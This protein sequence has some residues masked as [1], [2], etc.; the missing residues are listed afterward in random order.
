[1]AMVALPDIAP[2]NDIYSVS[3]AENNDSPN[4]KGI[5][6]E[7]DAADK[8]LQGILTERKV[9]TDHPVPPCPSSCHSSTPVITTVSLTD[10]ENTIFW[11]SFTASRWND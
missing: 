1:M 2:L 3:S 6:L 4:L 8:G 10:R 7:S 11:V 9:C 5:V